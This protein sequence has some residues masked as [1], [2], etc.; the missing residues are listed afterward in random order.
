[1]R[2]TCRD[3]AV[4]R[5]VEGVL[6][7]IWACHV[8]VI[9]ETAHTAHRIV[10]CTALHCW[11]ARPRPAPAH[12]APY[13]RVFAQVNQTVPLQAKPC[14]YERCLQGQVATACSM[15][16]SSGFDGPRGR[17]RRG[18]SWLSSAL[19]SLAT[20][21]NATTSSAC[22]TS[23]ITVS[24]RRTPAAVGDVLIAGY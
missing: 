4:C 1:M 20:C 17:S 7:C 24:T 14:I 10:A 11:H 18:P 2:R 5:R 23:E 8:G 3:L 19:S 9:I 15:P 16:S 13:L 21:I 12:R 6:S 22:C